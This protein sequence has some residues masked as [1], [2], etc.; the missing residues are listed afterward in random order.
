MTLKSVF[1]NDGLRSCSQ[2][3]SIESACIGVAPPNIPPVNVRFESEKQPL[4]M[5]V[6]VV[7]S[8]MGGSVMDW[9]EEQALNML[10]AVVRSGMGGSVRDWSE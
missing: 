4:N 5:L 2:L 7:T 9:S 8:G 1:G 10:V 6:A 3:R